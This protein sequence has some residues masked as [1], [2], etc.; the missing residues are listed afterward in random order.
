M[1][2]TANSGSSPLEHPAMIE[3]VPV[4]ATVVTLQLRSSC[5]GRIRAPDFV[6][7]ARCIGT[8]DAL[9]PFGERAAIGREAL[10][11]LLPF[12]VEELHHLAA[13]LDAFGAVIRNAEAHE[14]VG[15]THHAKSDAADA[16]RERV[17]FRQ[18]I[19]VDVDDVVE[20]VRRQMDVFRERIP[21]ELPV[22]T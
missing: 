15:E 10:A 3:I 9:R 21:V 7:R 6:A 13:E 16:L 4:G 5:I 22:V 14:R 19:L 12:D 17:D 18:R 11:L 1:N 20:E 2:A 8:P